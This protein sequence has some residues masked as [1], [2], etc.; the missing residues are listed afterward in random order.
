MHRIHQVIVIA[1]LFLLGSACKRKH[2]YNLAPTQ[3]VVIR[4]E[5]SST[6]FPS[7]VDVSKQYMQRYPHV[8]VINESTG[9]SSG[10]KQLIDGEINIARSSRALTEEDFKSGRSRGLSLIPYGVGFDAIAIIVHPSN[11]EM[12]K[13][14][15]TKKQVRGIFFDGSI[16]D[17][18]QLNSKLKGPIHAYAAKDDSSGTS[19]EF[20]KA[21]TGDSKREYA[22]NVI[23]VRLSTDVKPK[24][25]DDRGAIGYAPYNT[26]DD[27]TAIIPYGEDF[28]N[29]VTLTP[30]TIRNQSYALSRE[31][32]LVV[33]PPVK[34]NFAHF[35][36]FVLSATGQKL[37]K[38]HR[39]IPIQDLKDD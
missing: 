30:T 11:V 21:I 16:K 26:L 7:M 38:K 23:E 36:D 18:S 22:K 13:K 3:Q 2:E 28:D 15:L 24:V 8:K 35:I 10:I 20:I 17:W 6:L 32:Y 33:V 27:F 39:V 12:L 4:I 37:L 25:A 1:T 34:Y 5:G 29:I 19:A 31:L 14:G 9:S